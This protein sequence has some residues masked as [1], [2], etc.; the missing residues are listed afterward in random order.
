MKKKLKL[1]IF[2]SFIGGS[3][4]IPIFVISC[5]K[6][7]EISIN[8]K[9]KNTFNLNNHSLNQVQK[10]GEIKDFFVSKNNIEQLKIKEKNGKIKV[11]I[12]GKEKSFEEVIKLKNKYN[13]FYLKTYK[14]SEKIKII[15]TK[16]NEKSSNQDVNDLFFNE[17][18]DKY[19]GSN[20]QKYNEN[21]YNEYLKNIKNKFDLPTFNINSLPEV[22]NLI[23]LATKLTLFDPIFFNYVGINP[24][25]SNGIRIQGFMNSN[26]QQEYFRKILE[27]VF[28]EYNLHSNDGRKFSKLVIKDL[29]KLENF[30]DVLKLKFDLLDENGKS[31]LNSKNQSRYFL[32][33]GFKNQYYDISYPNYKY[34]IDDNEELFNEYVKNPTLTFKYNLLGIKSIEDI[35]RNINPIFNFNSQALLKM[36]YAFPEIFKIEVENKNENDLQ[37]KIVK[38]EDFYDKDFSKGVKNTKSLVCLTIE[39]TKK[40]GQK[41]YKKWYSSDFDTHNHLLSAYYDSD[42][43]EI[44]KLKNEKYGVNKITETNKKITWPKGQNFFDF[45]EKNLLNMFNYFANFYFKNSIL[46]KNNNQDEIENLEILEKYQ[47]SLKYFELIINTFLSNFI[48]DYIDLNTYSFDNFYIKNPDKNIKLRPFYLKIKVSKKHNFLSLKA[49]ELPIE[50]EWITKDEKGK[51]YDY[52]KL[53]N[54]YDNTILEAEKNAFLKQ[55]NEAKLNTIFS[56]KTYIWSGFKGTNF[57]KIDDYKK[58]NKEKIKNKN[59]PNN[60]INIPFLTVKN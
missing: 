20:F 50:F 43:L 46:W 15:K 38:V 7:Y 22:Q 37:Y 31:I 54:T 23:N 39:V 19:F 33:K 56:K 59:Y 12:N 9:I 18:Y 47:D 44:L 28:N 5:N 36:F 34:T 32:I 27:F 24:T 51:I 17:E 2:N 29:Q 3:F 52:E 35:L 57:K 45:L 4:F 14:T 13:Y 16:S 8:K 6:N 40:N 30:N 11:E 26:I 48:F 58:Q 60:E 1:I 10:L 42:N 41:E 53:E 21:N 25:F 55:I 49:G